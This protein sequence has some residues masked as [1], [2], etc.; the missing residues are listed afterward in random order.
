MSGTKQALARWLFRA[1]CVEK[2]E[3]P[4]NFRDVNFVRDYGQTERLF[5]RFGERLDLKGLSVLDFG[6]GRG[7]TC[8]YAALNGACRVVGVD[9][10]AD[11]I[12]Y[13]R[14]KLASDYPQLADRIEYKL[15]EGGL[16]EL[17][18]EQ[19]D[20]V[21]SQNAF[22]HYADPEQAVVEIR[23]ALRERGRLVAAFAPAWKAPTGGHL[24]IT[25]FPWAHLVFPEEVVMEQVRRLIP[26]DQVW[27]YEERGLNRMTVK[28]FRRIMAGSGLECLFFATNVSERP[29]MKL[30]R[31]AARIP[32]C[33]EYFTHNVYSIWSEP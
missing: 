23:R 7:P 4:E 32:G 6:C 13:A 20:L 1:V 18:G 27:G 14:R 25:R 16:A 9:I 29:A 33:A 31:A 10:N 17:G 11:H 22:E 3:R 19:F 24:T 21:V 12:D 5:R 2:V 15:T 8:I 30:M 26:R 28:R